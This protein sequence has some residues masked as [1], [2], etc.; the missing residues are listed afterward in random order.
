MEGLREPARFRARLLER[1]PVS[2]D[3]FQLD[4]E[5]PNGFHFSPGQGIRLSSEGLE[6]EYTLICGP[7]DERLSICVEVVQ[8]GR[9][10]PLLTRL[11]PGSVLEF[12]GPHGYLVYQTEIAAAI[13]VATGVGIAPFVSMVR[14]GL[15]GFTLL[16]GAQKKE[17][18]YY[19]SVV[20]SA[21]GRYLA[22][23]TRDHPEKERPAWEYCGRVT[24]F[25]R[26]GLP[27]GKLDFYL[28]GSRQM[29]RDVVDIVDDR[30]PES[31]VFFEAFF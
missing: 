24:D 6:R 16:H 1:T 28:C 2:T 29:I 15:S 13:F 23:L 22:C 4:F 21:A 14:G 12:T 9:F 17:G 8:G 20:H 11:A 25:L 18:L 26:T 30:F 19:R 3:A 10:S 5:R 27:A 31:R 7:S